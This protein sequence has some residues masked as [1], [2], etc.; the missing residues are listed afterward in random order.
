MCLEVAEHLPETAAASL[1]E[2][3]VNLSSVV[4]FSAAIPMQGGTNHINEQWPEYWRRLFQ[5]HGYRML[6][7][8][9][10][11]I[12][13]NAAVKFWYRQNTFLFVADRAKC[14]QIWHFPMLRARQTT[15]S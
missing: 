1:V 9:Q 10:R 4:L 7:L 2:S 8:I 11:E 14:P 6:D 15:Y 5:V 13:K 3:L 12:W